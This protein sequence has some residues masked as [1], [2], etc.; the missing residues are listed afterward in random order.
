MV[1]KVELLNRQELLNTFKG[2]DESN[3]YYELNTLCCHIHGKPK[4][5]YPTIDL[6]SLIN[7]RKKEC[8]IDN[9]NTIQIK[10]ANKLIENNFKD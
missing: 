1:I 10:I 3:W 2:C 4:D 6:K 8:L 5:Y 7:S 9:L